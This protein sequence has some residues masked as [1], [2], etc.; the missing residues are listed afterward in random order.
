MLTPS[1]KQDLLELIQAWR[2]SPH[3]STKLTTYFAAYASLFGSLRNQPCVFV[4]TGVLGGGSLFMWRKWLGSKARIVG[5]DLNPS[6]KKWEDHG[7]EVYIGDQGDPHFWGSVLEKVGPIDALLDD[8]G[9]QSFQQIVTLESCLRH[10]MRHSVIAIED[11]HTSY[12]NDFSRHGERHFLRYAKDA[13]DLLT[14]RAAEIYPTRFQ[15]VENK[16]AMDLFARVFSIQ[17]FGS[18][19]AFHIDPDLAQKP[20]GVWN[21]QPTPVKDFRYEGHTQATVCWPS[22]FQAEKVDVWGGE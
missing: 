19:V 18:L 13:S 16:E 2:D 12:M 6:A 9:H 1:F 5:I 8:G 7:F 10:A 14:A 3:P 11:T 15:A 4:E 21:R 22:P 17:F 20:K